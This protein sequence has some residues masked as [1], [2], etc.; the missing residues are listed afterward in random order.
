MCRSFRPQDRD[1]NST[2]LSLLVGAKDHREEFKNR[3]FERY[4]GISGMAGSFFYE[5]SFEIRGALRSDGSWRA[6]NLR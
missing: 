6:V 3:A 1:A 4:R 2:V 5:V